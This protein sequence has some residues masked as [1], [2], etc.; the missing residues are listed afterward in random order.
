MENIKKTYHSK[1]IKN[2]EV[3][4]LNMLKYLDSKREFNFMSKDFIAKEIVNN[5]EKFMKIKMEKIL[6][7]AKIRLPGYNSQEAGD[8]FRIYS[9][10]NTLIFKRTAMLPEADIKFLKVRY[11]SKLEKYLK[12]RVEEEKL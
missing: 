3:R 2:R 7:T 1:F 12:L 8:E 10:K 6:E 4:V 9:N 11:P 5:L